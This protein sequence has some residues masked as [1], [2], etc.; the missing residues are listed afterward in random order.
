[1]SSTTKPLHQ[2]YLQRDVQSGPGQLLN[3]QNQSTMKK[4]SKKEQQGIKGG[5]TFVECARDCRLNH[6]CTGP[7]RTDCGDYYLCLETNCYN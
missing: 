7:R 4:I 1:V 2:L 3:I 6:P 5:A